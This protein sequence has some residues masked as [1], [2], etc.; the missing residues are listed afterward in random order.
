MNAE[1]ENIIQVEHL[2][3]KFVVNK[4]SMEVLH[5]INLQV[6]KGEFITIKMCLYFLL[7]LLRCAFCDFGCDISELNYDF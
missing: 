7:A 2:N 6:K 4:Q 3:K 5:D 1:R